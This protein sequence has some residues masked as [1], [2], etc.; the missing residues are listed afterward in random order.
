MKKLLSFFLAI[1]LTVCLTAC[2]KNPSKVGSNETSIT[3]SAASLNSS[4]VSLTEN[5]SSQSVSSGVSSAKTSSVASGGKTSSTVSTAPKK[6]YSN[7]T[8]TIT[9][10]TQYNAVLYKGKIIT[11]RAILNSDYSI[12]TKYENTW[13]DKNN[14]SV[15]DGKLFYYD[16]VAEKYQTRS[17]IFTCDETGKNVKEVV[18]KAICGIYTIYQGRIYYFCNRYYVDYEWQTYLCSSNLDGTD[19]REEIYLENFDD[20]RSGVVKDSVLYFRVFINSIHS[21]VKFDPKVKKI[22]IMKQYPN[23]TSYFWRSTMVLQGNDFYYHYIDNLYKVNFNGED[24]ALPI[25]P[26]ESDTY[27]R[28]K[29]VAICD[30]G[31]MVMGSDYHS[32]YEPV[33]F[34][35]FD[36]LST[37]KEAPENLYV[38]VIRSGTGDLFTYFPYKKDDKIIL[39]VSGRAQQ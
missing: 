19:E 33:D 4:T 7:S 18:K 6:D 1:C 16:D 2:G 17:V 36:D 20:F 14:I 24:I 12:Y 28:N 22:E 32:I 3:S 15:Y 10:P 21:I 25:A 39:F 30:Q 9:I 26:N 11:P 27:L 34:F 8:E 23:P 29:N 35:Y 31:V 38:K 13:D 5:D 37:K